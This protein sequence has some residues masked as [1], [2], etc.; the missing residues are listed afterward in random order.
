[1]C[2]ACT[3]AQCPGVPWSAGWRPPWPWRCGNPAL[4]SADH[5]WA[6]GRALRAVISGAHGPQHPRA[7]PAARLHPGRAEGGGERDRH[8]PE[9]P[10]GGPGR[11]LLPAVRDDGEGPAA[12]HWCE[13]PRTTWAAWGGAVP[14]EPWP[15]RDGLPRSSGPCSGWELAGALGWSV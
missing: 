12:A 9:G 7:E 13:W 2:P 8:G 6:V 15:A 14:R 10:Q 3:R 11:P 4:C 5:T 1:M